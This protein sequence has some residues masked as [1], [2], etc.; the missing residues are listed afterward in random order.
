MRGNKCELHA[1]YATVGSDL[2]KRKP[3]DAQPAD[4]GLPIADLSVDVVSQQMLADNI[5]AP[6]SFLEAIVDPIPVNDMNSLY[7]C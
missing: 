1:C 2:L 4:Y 7:N 6:R 3:G 5:K